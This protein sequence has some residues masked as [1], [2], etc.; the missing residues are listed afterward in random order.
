MVYSSI[1]YYEIKIQAIDIGEIVILTTTTN[2]TNFNVTGLLTGTSHELTV[3]A[4]SEDDNTTARSLESTS[5]VI[6]V[7]GK[8]IL[9]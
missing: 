8:I 6:I 5:V 9:D 2:T 3:V 4:I 1:S 7:T